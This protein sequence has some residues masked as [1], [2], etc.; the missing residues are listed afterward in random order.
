MK[1]NVLMDVLKPGHMFKSN[2]LT[3]KYKVG[4]VGR[5]CPVPFGA[6][7]GVML[8]GVAVVGPFKHWHQAR[9]AADQRNRDLEALVEVHES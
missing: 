1:W 4:V 3:R 2:G 9:H 8:W 7:Y 6:R 5:P